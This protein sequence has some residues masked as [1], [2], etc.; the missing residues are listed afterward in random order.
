MNTYTI[1]Q[2]AQ[3][4]G[5]SVKTLQRWDREG[6]LS[7]SRTPTNRRVYTD[8]D[9]YKVFPRGQAPTRATVVYMR[10]SSQAQKPD[11][12]NQR[13]VLEQFCAA[14]GL[15][16]T[17]W[18]SE[19]GGGLN[20]KRPQ[21]LALVDRIV[22]N[23]VAALVIA[24]QDRLVRFGCDLLSHLCRTHGCELLVMHTETLSP[25]QEMVQDLMTITH[26]FS[27]R[28]SGLR[29]YRKALQKALSDAPSAQDPPAS[30]PGAGGLFSPGDRDATLCLSLGPGTHQRVPRR[31]RKTSPCL[32]V[33]EN[34]QCDEGGTIP[35]GL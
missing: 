12:A 4:I 17:Q 13:I 15:T 1:A 23:Q 26:C 8:E 19:I 6:R 21:F 16:V 9:L 29:T 2:F 18:I 32:G 25:E 20:F 14:R 27:A 30:S 5:V 33:E 10:V 34:V 35:L 24:H 11:L 7:P 22:T 3:R 31:R 28:L